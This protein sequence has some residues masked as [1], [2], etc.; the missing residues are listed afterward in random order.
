MRTFPIALLLLASLTSHAAAA[1]AATAKLRPFGILVGPVVRLSDLFDGLGAAGRQVL[2][3]G[4]AP[5]QQI[6][7]PAAQLAAIASEFGV[8]WRPR[9]PGEQAVLERPGRPLRRHEVEPPLHE[10]LL[11]AGAPRDS[12]VLLPNFS[13]PDVPPG[14]AVELA[15]KQLDYDRSS[16]D[17]SAVL[18]IS[19][20][21][22]DPEE[23]AISGRAEPTLSII[24]ASHVLM[25]GMILTAADLKPADVP[26]GSF[27][28]RVASTDAQ[29]VGM[30]IHRAVAAG[31]P[32]PLSDLS[33][34]P[35]VKR[36]QRILIALDA[37]GLTLTEQ[38]EALQSGARD[39]SVRVLNT[40]SHAILLGT[41][42]GPGEVSVPLG[43]LPLAAPGAGPGTSYAQ[44]T[45]PQPDYSEY[46]AQ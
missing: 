29:A 42:I 6:T 3:P 11:A 33:R 44:S 45:Y 5:G 36:G 4:P 1:S 37:P 41:V 13:P 17:F 35:L 10:A 27:A 43:S 2:G 20:S 40:V 22:M 31:D 39:D 7:V 23:L 34:P 25:P 26:A 21:G 32:L 18:A 46:A 19:A 30:E 28:G 16:G 24:V 12:R 38:G 14:A 15:I 9:S 8:D